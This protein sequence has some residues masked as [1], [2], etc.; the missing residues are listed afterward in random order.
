M[1]KSGSEGG[2]LEYSMVASNIG[3]LMWS[4]DKV[5]RE[6]VDDQLSIMEQRPHAIP[7]LAANGH[8]QYRWLGANTR[9]QDIVKQENMEVKAQVAVETG[10]DFDNMVAHAMDHGESNSKS[11]GQKKLP[12]P[13]N[14]DAIKLKPETSGQ[15]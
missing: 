11:K 6:K 7:V 14:D 5:H 8:M 3:L 9:E 1:D 15:E 13:P 12:K 4:S 2:W 10:K